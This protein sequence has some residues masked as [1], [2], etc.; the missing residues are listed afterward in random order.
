MHKNEIKIAEGFKNPIFLKPDNNYTNLS[1][2]RRY[3]PEPNPN[4][5]CSTQTRLLLPEPITKN[6]WKNT[7]V[8]NLWYLLFHGIGKNY[9]NYTCISQEIHVYDFYRYFLGDLGSKSICFSIFKLLKN[10]SILY[11]LGE[12]ELHIEKKSIL[13]FFR[14]YVLEGTNFY[15]KS[16]LAKLFLH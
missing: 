12:K 1:K 6:E 14:K 5:R 10:K 7:L 4:L 2:T 16:Y 13:P 8:F 11:I 9:I 15:G 3:N